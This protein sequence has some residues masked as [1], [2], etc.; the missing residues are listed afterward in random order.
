MTFVRDDPIINRHD[1]ILFT[2]IVED[3]QV[4]YYGV[5]G[6]DPNF[7]EMKKVV[8]IEG[9]RPEIPNRWLCDE[10]L[11]AFG[12]FIA[13]KTSL[14]HKFCWIKINFLN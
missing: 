9:R 1:F 4:P 6:H 8:C 14:C 10:V 12:I 11:T 13:F 3:Y 5:V 7:D 2:G